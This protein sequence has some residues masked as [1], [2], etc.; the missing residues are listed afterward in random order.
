V[1]R[2][3]RPLAVAG[4]S[5][6]GEA[7]IFLDLDVAPLEKDV[8]VRK[9]EAPVADVAVGGGGRYLILHLPKLSKLAVFDANKAK[10]VKLLPA[11]DAGLKFTAGLD[12][13]LIALPA[14]RTIQRWNLETLELEQT[15]PYPTKGEVLA[16]SLGAASSGPALVIAKEPKSFQPS[17]FLLG[18]E[19]LDK[20]VFVWVGNAHHQLGARQQLHMR[21]SYD[22][23]GTGLWAWGTFPTGVFWI[24]WDNLF[25]R[26]DY[27]HSSNGHV[28]PGPGGKVLFTGLGMYTSVGFVPG[29]NKPYPGSDPNG[30][31]V[32]AHHSDYYLYLGAAP[33]FTNKN[34]PR[35][36]SIH[37]LGVAKPVLS[38]DGIEVPHTDEQMIKDDFTLDKRF[39]LIPQAKL[40]IEIPTSNDRLVL[41]RVDLEAAQ[42]KAGGGEK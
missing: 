27:T 24:R 26:A 34:P 6:A 14:S 19:K 18:L 20:K 15:V 16:L 25:A 1:G 42:K 7:D 21:T 35:A 4:A 12:R 33:T 32:P 23:K 39:H 9:L 31:Y 37:K 11:P 40:L 2:L 10:V 22:G 36:F 29:Q 13:L 5:R 30:R 3:T 17:A 8:V 38:L 28:I 41:R